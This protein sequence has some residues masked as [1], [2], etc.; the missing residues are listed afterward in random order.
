M[1]GR[2]LPSSIASLPAGGGVADCIQ[3]LAEERGYQLDDSQLLAVRHLQRLCND[4]SKA[5]ALGRL[6]L[7]K[8]FTRKNAPRG[9]YLWGGV[10]RGKSFLMD[11]FFSCAPVAHK[12]RVHFHHLMQEIH[13]G[14][15][16]ATGHADPLAPVAREI[17]RHTRLLCLDEFHVNDIADAM[18][19]RGL[20][21]ALLAEGVVLVITSN[22]EPG[23][24]YRNGLQRGQFL[25]A[26]ALIRERFEVVRVEGGAD[27]RQRELE[28]APRYYAPPDDGAERALAGIFDAVA[29]GRG[30]A[31]ATL[32]VLGRPLVVRRVAP[33]AAWFDFH[34][35]C[36][37]PRG[38]ADYIEIARRFPT[39]LISGVPQMTP[40]LAAEARRF[41][42][43]V[44]ELYDRRVRLFI[45]SA[46]SLP[47]LYRGALIGEDFD[48][49]LSRLKEMQ[50]REYGE[51]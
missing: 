20:L 7:F 4:L 16:T 40:P 51:P 2:H 30:E 8:R 39:V 36:G 42:W 18:L 48:R 10:G 33:G 28:Q 15:K 5:G 37:G 46:A 45:S 27:Y 29:G 17:S 22:S 3:A 41:V 26:I 21:Q 12:K 38:K 50:S 31:Q 34:A 32:N 23:D 19:M 9:V 35:L 49:T 6:P 14:L 47:D 24:L 25:P 11:G 1:N 44:D 43:L 13:A